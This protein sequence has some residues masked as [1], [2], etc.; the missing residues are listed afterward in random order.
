MD[1]DQNKHDP[2]ICLTDQKRTGSHL[3]A[4]CKGDSELGRAAEAVVEV[5]AGDYGVDFVQLLQRHRLVKVVLA[6]V[7]EPDPVHEALVGVTRLI[8]YG[9][10]HVPASRSSLLHDSWQTS[11]S[12]QNTCPSVCFQW[13]RLDDACILP[14]VLLMSIVQSCP[15]SRAELLRNI[16]VLQLYSPSSRPNNL[17]LCSN[18]TC[19]VLEAWR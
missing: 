7:D 5:L 18:Q 14:R 12:A 6:V 11:G 1:H 3:K 8:L 16:T 10:P 15:K 2:L 17:N 19:L 13:H 9:L 4:S